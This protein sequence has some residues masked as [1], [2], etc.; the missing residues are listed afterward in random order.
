MES[1]CPGLMHKARAILCSRFREERGEEPALRSLAI[2]LVPASRTSHKTLL[3]NKYQYSHFVCINRSLGA[4]NFTL[5]SE[6][7]NFASKLYIE[8]SL[9][10]SMFVSSYS[11][12]SLPCSSYIAMVPIAPR[13]VLYCYVGIPSIPCLLPFFPV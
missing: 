4:I 9:P 1:C 3:G 2:L 12:H 11:S 13:P 7:V 10:T 8:F 6:S 5:T